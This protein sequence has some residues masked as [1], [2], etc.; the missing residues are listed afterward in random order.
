MLGAVA[1]ISIY[2]EVLPLHKE[3]SNYYF[4]MRLPNQNEHSAE[5]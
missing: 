4:K 2:G 1:E 3:G 5:Q